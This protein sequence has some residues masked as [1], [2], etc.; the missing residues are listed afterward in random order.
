MIPVRAIY[1]LAALAHLADPVT[2]QQSFEEAVIAQLRCETNPSPL[3]ILEA[4][5][6]A[7]RIDP[8]ANIGYDSLSCFL[9]SGGGA[10]VAGM[11]FNSICAHEEDPEVRARRPDLLYRGPG[12]SPG[13][14][15]SF[16][17]SANEGVAAQWYAEVIGYRHLSEAIASEYTSVGDRTEVACS[18]RFA[19]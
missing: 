15:L 19:G 6:A 12:T 2:A 13:Q 17:T 16:G 18:S 5:V 7:G 14:T 11:T 8:N 3:P 10:S 9:I 4:L 1:P